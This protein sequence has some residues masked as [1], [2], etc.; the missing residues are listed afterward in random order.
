MSNLANTLRMYAEDMH[1]ATGYSERSS[2]MSKAADMIEKFENMSACEACATIPSVMEYVQQL[3]QERDNL[4]A[5]NEGMREAI[6]VY[7]KQYPHM[8]KG[9]ILDAINSPNLAA[10]VL[11]RRDATVESKL[12]RGLVSGANGGKDGRITCKDLLDMVAE[13]EKETDR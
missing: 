2:A 1:S 3:E 4:A 6:E 11:K 7:F 10:E 5:Q 12:L 9:Y 13:I 8:M